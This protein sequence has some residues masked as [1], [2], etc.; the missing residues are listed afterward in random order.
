[1]TESKNNIRWDQKIYRDKREWQFDVSKLPGCNEK[2]HK[3][4]SLQTYQEIRKIS[5]IQPN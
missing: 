3:F 2:N 4:I 5:N 1:M